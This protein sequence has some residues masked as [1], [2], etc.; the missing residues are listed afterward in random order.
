MLTILFVRDERASGPKGVRARGRCSARPHPRH[1]MT[2]DPII[3]EDMDTLVA[4][5][6]RLQQSHSTSLPEQCSNRNG[7]VLL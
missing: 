1:N 5:K 7:E 4:Q 2:Y 6:N 3:D